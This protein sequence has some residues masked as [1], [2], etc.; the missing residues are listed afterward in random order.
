MVLASAP[1]CTLTEMSSNA[2]H[3]GYSKSIR[4]PQFASPTVIVETQGV[5]HLVL[6]LN[7]GSSLPVSIRYSGY[8]SMIS[9]ILRGTK[10]GCPLSLL[11]FVLAI[12]P[13]VQ[14]IGVQWNISGM[15]VA[16]Y[17]HKICL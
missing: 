4:L 9:P 7:Y 8:H 1:Q 16:G 2:P 13:L 3:A 11:L 5:M 6:E 10:Q 15:E 12:V 17:H 14:A